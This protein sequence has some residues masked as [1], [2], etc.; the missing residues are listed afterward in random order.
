MDKQ[1]SV[2]L[3][4][5][6]E[7]FLKGKNRKMFEKAA[8]TNI[9][10]MITQKNLNGKVIP[11]RSRLYIYP[12]EQETSKDYS[13]LQRIFGLTSYSP[14]V[15]T[16][17]TKDSILK[18]TKTLLEKKSFN[19]FS[20]ATKRLTK[21]GPLSSTEMNRWLGAEIV[22]SHNKKV[23][24]T[25]PDL[26][27]IIEIKEDQANIATQIFPC[28]GGL[29]VG[30]TG[31]VA[32]LTDQAEAELAAILMA[33]RGCTINLIGQQ[34]PKYKILPNF[35]PSTT[36]FHE[37]THN[38]KIPQILEITKSIALVSA[39]SKPDITLNKVTTLYPLIGK[40]EEDIKIEIT[41]YE[42]IC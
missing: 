35:L 17:A 40:T 38:N 22:K 29:P 5:Y 25:N 20:V 7:L 31:S 34:D 27:I 11:T 6:G 21:T 33:K 28:P 23:D 42:N 30:V 8:A 15:E 10:K 12:T 2:I 41:H 26:Q 16:S 19:T 3:C 39:H 9:K 24:L 36:T 18:T 14:A 4:R 32:V 13:F 1:K 37:I